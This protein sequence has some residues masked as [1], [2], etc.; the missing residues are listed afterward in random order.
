MNNI[1]YK[2]YFGSIEYNKNDKCLYG[3]VFGM[4]KDLILNL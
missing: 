2:G 3:K 1:E 4:T